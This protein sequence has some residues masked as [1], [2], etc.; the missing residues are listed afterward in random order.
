M[1]APINV[2]AIGDN[3]GNLA[4]AD[5]ATGAVLGTVTLSR[6]Y[7]SAPG[8]AWNGILYAGKAPPSRRR[9]CTLTTPPCRRSPTA[10]PTPYR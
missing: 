9:C 6:G 7:L 8:L 5:S 10:G 4:F 2:L 3:R 1:T